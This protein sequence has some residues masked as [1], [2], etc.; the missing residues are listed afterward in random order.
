MTRC[1]LE[2]GGT[3]VS[4][5]SQT[6]EAPTLPLGDLIYRNISLRSFFIVNWVRQ[7]PRK[8]IEQTYAELADLV[9]QGVLHAAVEATYPIA[10]YRAALAHAQQPQRSGKILFTPARPTGNAGRT[11]RSTNR[12]QRTPAAP[13]GAAGVA[14]QTTTR[15]GHCGISRPSPSRIRKGVPR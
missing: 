2:S 8:E 12:R 11:R 14:G 6:G 7:T 1:A 10:Q 4:Y 13:I 3:V 15:G 9:E 5:S